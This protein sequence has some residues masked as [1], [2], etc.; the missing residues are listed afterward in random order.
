MAQL[1]EAQRKASTSIDG[2]RMIYAG[3]GTGKTFTIT[4]RVAYMLKQG[5]QPSEILLLTFTNK[6]AKEMKERI[7]KM[8]GEEATGITACTFH[9]FCAFFLRRN[10][11]LLSLSPNYTIL[12]SGDSIDAISIAKQEFLNEQKQAG[13]EYNLKDFPT[14]KSIAQ[15]YEAAVNNCVSQ[16]TVI[17]TKSEWYL[18]QMEILDILEHYK[19]YKKEKDLLDYEDLLYLTERLLSENESLRARMDAK[20]RYISC[21]EYQDTNTIQDRILNAMSRDYPNLCVVGDDNQSIYAF[22]YADIRNILNFESEHPGCESV[23]LDTNY[24]SSQEILDTAN[25]MMEH[26]VEGKEKWLKGLFHGEKPKA[27]VVDNTYDEADYILEKIR[28]RTC[29]LKDI[30]V[31]CRSAA[32]SYILE[33]RLTAMGIPYEKFGGLKFMERPTVKNILSFLRL[34]VNEKDELSYYRLLQLYPGIGK[35]YAQKLAGMLSREGFEKAKITYKKRTFAPYLAELEEELALLKTKKLA[36]QLEELLGRYYKQTV[37][38]QIAM[39]KT[40]DGKK[41]ELYA[42]L[43]NNLRDADTLRVIAQPYRTT[44]R[45][46]ADMVLDAVVE[47]ENKDKLNITTIHSAKGLE[48]HT[49]FVMDCIEGVTPSCAENSEEDSEELRCMYVAIT[50]AKKELYLMVPR[51]YNMK[52]IQGKLTHFLNH[53]NVLETL[54]C[55][56]PIQ[57]L[58]NLAPKF[59]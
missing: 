2:Y 53:E 30:A 36:E 13:N 55:N 16:K 40:S 38:R 10:A 57:E 42:A 25:A 59:F 52:N 54:S 48:Y 34:C 8:I 56:I 20:Y 29:E 49:V 47:K 9:S 46:L 19:N 37:E 28:N 5:I 4:A 17:N 6:A 3:A 27:I 39:M 31:I 50:R 45:F 12:D 24:R 21:D 22:R 11:N 58:E 18:Y 51:F 1:N 26:A 15:V 7:I 23:I 33:S 14:S 41:S 35:T 32:Q 43:H 44:S